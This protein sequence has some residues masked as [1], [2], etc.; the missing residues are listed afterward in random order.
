MDI[1]KRKTLKKSVVYR[2]YSTI[3]GGLIAFFLTGK[4]EI[5]MAF[6]IIE[7]IIKTVS[8]YIFEKIYHKK[9]D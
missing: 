5:S 9:S 8:Y 4:V 2:I 6:M 3:I 7:S 1:N